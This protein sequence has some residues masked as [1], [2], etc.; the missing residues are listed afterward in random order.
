MLAMVTAS[1]PSAII[2]ETK[3]QLE[4]GSIAQAELESEAASG[5]SQI[6]DMSEL[7]G[8]LRS[9]V[10]KILE[11][12]DDRDAENVILL[13]SIRWH[14]VGKSGSIVDRI[15]ECVKNRVCHP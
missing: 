12:L 9:E 14:K 2:C 3:F 5:L 8:C 11:D 7:S 6:L 1:N 13:A 4:S 10:E 15:R